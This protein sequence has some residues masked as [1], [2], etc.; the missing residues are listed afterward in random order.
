[1]NPRCNLPGCDAPSIARSLCSRHYQQ[2]KYGRKWAEYTTAP[3][4]TGRPEPRYCTCTGKTPE[5]DP[6]GMCPEC[7]RLVESR[8]ADYGD[9]L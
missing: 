3:R 2:W 1:M 6:N 5:P 4:D 7:F 9:T 8:A